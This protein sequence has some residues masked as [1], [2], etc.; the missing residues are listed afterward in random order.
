MLVQEVDSVEWKVRVT[1]RTL[2]YSFN[3]LKTGFY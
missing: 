3:M 1:I 2:G